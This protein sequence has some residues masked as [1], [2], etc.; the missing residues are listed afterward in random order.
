ML[1]PASDPALDAV[2]ITSTAR[3]REHGYPWADWDLLRDW[4]PIYLYEGRPRFAPF[5]AVTRHRDIRWISSQPELFSNTGVIRLDTERGQNQLADY[6]RKRAERNG[7]NPDVALD[8]LY[9]DR[10]EH[11][12]LRS[13]AARRFTPRAMN[14]MAAHLDDVAGEFVAHFADVARRAAPDAVD[15]TEEL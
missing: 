10:P 4:A 13:L 2:D 9:T 7:W 12:D 11:F 6:R 5:W 15:L 14:R 8:M 3:Y 1:S